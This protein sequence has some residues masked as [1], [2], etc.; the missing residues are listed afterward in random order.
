MK[1]QI[2]EQDGVEAL[3]S[4]CNNFVKSI[5]GE[6]TPASDGVDGLNVARVL[7]AANKSLQQDGKDIPP[8]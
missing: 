7:E 3:S 8:D 1:R 4:L 2:G 5:S 6:A